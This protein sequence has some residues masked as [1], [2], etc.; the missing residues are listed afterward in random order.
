MGEEIVLEYYAIPNLTKIIRLSEKN[1]YEVH[2]L[3]KDSIIKNNKLFIPR[4]AF[5]KEEGKYTT[6]FGDWA[7]CYKNYL[8]KNSNG[9]WDVKNEKDFS[10]Y[11]T[12]I[13]PI[14]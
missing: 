12:G 7:E 3:I 10:E 13:K 14:K 1:I 4:V 8:V 2:K 5:D 9:G 11:Y 6:I